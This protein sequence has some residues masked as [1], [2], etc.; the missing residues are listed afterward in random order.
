MKLN[1]IVLSVLLLLIAIGAFGVT[2][3]ALQA[4]DS[5]AVL[6]VNTHALNVRTGPTYYF[7]ILTTVAGGSKL[8]VIGRGSDNVWYLVSTEAGEGWVNSEFTILRGNFDNIPTIS[9]S[10]AN[11]SASAAMS[12]A[13]PSGAGG[14]GTVC[15]PGEWQ[16]TCGAQGC[17]ASHTAQCNAAGNGWT[18]VWDPK[19]CSPIVPAK[20]TCPISG[21]C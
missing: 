15:N 2:A 10:K 3:V 21:S 1:R 5:S 9:V 14:G 20:P 17:P 4:A 19:T 16:A 6:V 13:A 12:F 11:Q 8:P 18:C 7:P